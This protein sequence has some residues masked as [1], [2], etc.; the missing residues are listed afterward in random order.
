[1]VLIVDHRMLPHAAHNYA[2]IDFGW[3]AKLSRYRKQRGL[4]FFHSDHL[5]LETRLE[6]RPSQRAQDV[7]EALRFQ[8]PDRCQW[9]RFNSDVCDSQ[10]PARGKAKP[11]FNTGKKEKNTYNQKHVENDR[12]KKST[13]KGWGRLPRN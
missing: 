9:E 7:N 11:R 6:I 4:F 2:Q 3:L 5:L 8:K 1:M 12:A 13:K 10:R